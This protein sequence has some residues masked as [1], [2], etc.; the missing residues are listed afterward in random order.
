MWP[1]VDLVVALALLAACVPAG[2]QGGAGAPAR[3][4]GAIV[5]PNSVLRPIFTTTA[6]TIE[7]GSAFVVEGKRG[8]F[9]LLTAHHL[10]GPAGGL[11]S[12]IAWDAMPTVVQRV[13]A[14]SPD[15]GAVVVLG[16]GP[17]AI[18][19]AQ[20][21]NGGCM[22]CDFAVFPVAGVGGAGILRLATAP[23]LVGGKVFLVAELSD[24]GPKRLHPAT[25]IGVHDDY[26]AY[27]FEGSIDLRATSGAPVVNEA[28]EVVAVNLGGRADP[29]GTLGIGAA[30]VIIRQ[31]LTAVGML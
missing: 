6:G 5:P 18:E 29:E 7:A 13:R 16:R 15:D 4:S 3:R 14:V 22:G 1:R 31:K 10:F 21:M 9:L 20:A 11:E 30:S 17:L 24:G 28:G 8:K 12:E 2:G 23:P 26:L 19:G 27:R 25:L